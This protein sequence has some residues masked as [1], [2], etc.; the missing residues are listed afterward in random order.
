[1]KVPTGPDEMTSGERNSG[2]L[3]TP[4]WEE[5]DEARELPDGDVLPP[6]LSSTSWA[7]PKSISLSWFA[8]VSRRRFS[9]W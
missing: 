2:L 1:M 8:V 3:Q 9:G 4:S 6:P 5:D 7:L